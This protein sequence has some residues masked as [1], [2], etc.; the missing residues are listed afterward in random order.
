MSQL[1][2]LK[3]KSRII[4]TSDGRYITDNQKANRVKQLESQVA[5]LKEG[6]IKLEKEIV[7]ENDEIE[8]TS[9]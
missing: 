7:Q 8:R 4:D 6:I 3:I 5:Q 1:S 2:H 9:D